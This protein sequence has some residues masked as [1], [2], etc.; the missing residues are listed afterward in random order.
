M[1]LEKAYDTVNREAL[2]QVLIMYDV[3]VNY[4]MAT[5]EC[6]LTVYPVLEY[7]D[8]RVSVFGSIMV[9]ER[10]V[11]YPL[12]SSV[13]IWMQWWRRQKWEWDLRSREESGEYPAAC[14]QMTWFCVASQRKTWWQWWGVLLVC[15]RRG[16][17]VNAGKSKVMVLCGEEELEYEVCM[18]GYI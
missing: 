18:M 3:G 2:W 11:S 16:L 14:M 13:Y 4:W 5:R 8:L 15:R 7:R 6:T 17:K 10:G 1:D 9:W 12:D